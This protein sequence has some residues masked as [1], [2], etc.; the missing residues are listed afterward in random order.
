MKIAGMAGIATLACGLALST[1][2]VPGLAQELVPSKTLEPA[3]GGST[4]ESINAAYERE[5]LKLERHRLQTPSAG[6][7]PE[8]AP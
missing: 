6:S 8:S 7:P 2:T 1:T 4:V 5:L 3:P